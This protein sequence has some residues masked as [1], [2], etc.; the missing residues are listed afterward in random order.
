MSQDAVKRSYKQ[1]NSQTY[2]KFCVVIEDVSNPGQFI[3][4]T[5]AN[6]GPIAG[7]SQN[8]I[9]ATGQSDYI[10]G[11]F[12]AAALTGT[13]WPAGYPGSGAGRNIDVVVFGFSKVILASGAVAVGDRLT[14]ADS[15][16]RVASIEANGLNIA[17]GTLVN[18]LGTAEEIASAANDVFVARI[19]PQP[20]K[21]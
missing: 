14:V 19:N 21:I 17:G 4:P 10:A 15:N 11:I 8:S 3:A 9:L 12:Q 1:T 5:G 13:A 18:I 7:V 2:C 20:V 6:V 16:G